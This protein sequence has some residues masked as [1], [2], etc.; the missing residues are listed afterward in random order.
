[1][2]LSIQVLVSILTL[3][4]TGY[5]DAI[6]GFV[7]KQT[8]DLK[9]SETRFQLVVKVTKDGIWDWVDTLT[10]KQYWSPQF[11]NCLDTTQMR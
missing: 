8:F 7:K 10:E 5:S 9:E 6:E 3:I 1:V 11:L 2:G 4:I